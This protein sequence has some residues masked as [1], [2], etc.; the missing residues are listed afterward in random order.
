ML[1]SANKTLEG[2]STAAILA[3]GIG[4]LYFILDESKSVSPE[5]IAQVAKTTQEFVSAIATVPGSDVL[6][7]QLKE[8]GQLGLVLGFMYKVFTSFLNSRTELKKEELRIKAGQ[9]SVDV[10]IE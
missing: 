3:S 10:P 9:S 4:A 6:F 7:I 8:L 1:K 5:H 2:Q